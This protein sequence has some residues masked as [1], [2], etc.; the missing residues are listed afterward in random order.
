MVSRKSKDKQRNAQ[1]KK[2]K[3]INNDVPNITQ[4]PKD[5]ATRCGRSCV[6]APTES[7]QRL[8]NWY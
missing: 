2:N 7:N 3:R 1:K 5:R 8:R 4:K 6:R